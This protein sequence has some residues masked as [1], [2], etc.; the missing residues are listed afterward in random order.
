MAAYNF[1]IVHLCV[2]LC[3][4]ISLVS[5]VYGS[6][7]TVDL[8]HR[9]SPRSPFFSSADKA[10]DRAENAIRRSISRCNHFGKK[11]SSAKSSNKLGSNITSTVFLDGV[12]DYLMLLAVGTPA[13]PLLAIADTG[14]DI[15]WFQCSPCDVCFPQITSP[16]FAPQNS[17]T[18]IDIP[19]ATKACDALSSVSNA[20]PC[21][22]A[23]C[24]YN[25]S[26]GDGSISIG[27]FARETLTFQSTSGAETN[28]SV[29]NMAFGCGHNNTGIFS[30][31]GAGLVG[32]D[33]GPFSLVSQLG[34]SIDNKFSY[35]LVNINSKTATSKLTFGSNPKLVSGS[36]VVSTPIVFKARSSFYFLTLEA[37]S[38]GE[39]RIPF[40]TSSTTSAVPLEQ[41]NIVIDS[42]STITSLPTDFY[43]AFEAEMKKA[44]TI[45]P[46]PDPNTSLSLCY[47]GDSDPASVPTV[48]AHF[49]GADIVLSLLN[50]FRLNGEFACLAFR[51]TDGLAIYGNVV[52]N[53]FI[54]EYD[55]VNKL[56]SFMSTD[57]EMA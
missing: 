48:T 55:L 10:S 18:Y 5:Y 6:G 17:S 37:I 50:L 27:N 54:V 36:G 11:S 44:I 28:I 14:S 49:T 21:D 9:D 23:A 57:C 8:I 19:C 4:T 30:A 46:V 56:V 47:P 25:I 20:I 13:L 45:D 39:T 42:G 1:S 29:S 35:C 38:V 7:F 40:N 51:P 43:A 26:Y 2:F 53:N 52:Q 24:K 22:G 33:A 16:I 12:G 31:R 15:I 3:Y 32:L 41:G 34:S